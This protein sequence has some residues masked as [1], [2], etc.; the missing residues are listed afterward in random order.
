[1]G[2]T[3]EDDKDSAIDVWTSAARRCQRW[4]LHFSKTLFCYARRITWKFK[5]SLMRR[6]ARHPSPRLAIP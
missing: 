2:D 4:R 5:R 1:M 3:T 6:A